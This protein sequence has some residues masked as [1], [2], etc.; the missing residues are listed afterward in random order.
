MNQNLNKLEVVADENNRCGE[1]PLWDPEQKR[2]LWT[3]IESALVYQ[4]GPAE[5][6][7]AVISRNLAVSAI[8]LNKFGELIFGGAGGWHLARTK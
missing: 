2:L 8:A 1:G 4:L 6:E 3:D 7:K 5:N